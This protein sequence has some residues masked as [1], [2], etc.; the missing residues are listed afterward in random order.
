MIDFDDLRTEVDKL[1]QNQSPAIEFR[2]VFTKLQNAFRQLEATGEMRRLEDIFN[3]FIDKIPN[4]SKLKRIKADAKDMAFRLTLATVDQCLESMEARNKALSNLT[5]KLDEEIA[6]ANADANKLKTIKDMVEK[7]TGL[8][9]T[10]KQLIDD[11]NVT[12]A[13]TKTRLKA[14]V[15]A[16]DNV[17]NIFKPQ[18]T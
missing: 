1:D 8:V 9:T 17:S 5:K 15:T 14:L 18:D 3:D 11:L 10:V 2:R 7:A 16:L 4:L 13:N 6:G 12:G